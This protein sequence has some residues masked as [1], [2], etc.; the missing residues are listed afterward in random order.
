MLPLL[1]Y[2]FCAENG[3]QQPPHALAGPLK[4]VLWAALAVLA[5]LGLGQLH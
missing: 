2:L 4:A 1:H 5:G 3:R